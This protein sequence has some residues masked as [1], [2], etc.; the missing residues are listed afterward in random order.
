MEIF[1]IGFGQKTAEQFFGSLK[2]AGIRRLIDVRLNNVSQLAGFT[3]RDDLPFFLHELCAA[4][5]VYEPMLAPTRAIRDQWLKHGGP[6][7]R[8]EREFRTLMAERESETRLSRSLF[9][10]PTALLC[11]EP[12]AEHCHRRLVLEYLQAKWDGIEIVHLGRRV[13]G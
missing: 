11:A 9:E 6:W 5:Y 10:V 7:Q 4:E 1:T 8:Y 12:T 3:K 2:A 13:S